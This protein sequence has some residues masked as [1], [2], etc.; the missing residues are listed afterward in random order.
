MHQGKGSKMLERMR[1]VT[2]H[3]AKFASRCY[4]RAKA[5]DAKTTTAKLLPLIHA[6]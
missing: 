3:N 6:D 5:T 4:K 2:C 1:S